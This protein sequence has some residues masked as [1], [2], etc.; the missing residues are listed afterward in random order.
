[1]ADESW[2]FFWDS[3]EEDIGKVLD[4]KAKK[5]HAAAQKK[6]QDY[7]DDVTKDMPT[8]ADDE[9]DAKD[10]LKKKVEQ[11]EEG[12][13]LTRDPVHP[14]EN[15]KDKKDGD[16][17]DG[18]KGQGSTPGDTSGEA[19]TTTNPDDDTPPPVSEEEAKEIIKKAT[20]IP[21][22]VIT[23]VDGID[24]YDI[25]VPEDPQDFIDAVNG[26]APMDPDAKPEPTDPSYA[27]PTPAELGDPWIN[28]G[29]PQDEFA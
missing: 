11:T 22:H 19:G 3:L 4:A 7:A 15:D 13:E 20:G 24:F 28:P 16:K 10:W 29:N 9:K 6:Q 12:T 2:E 18:D 1:F 8:E 26:D 25:K 23:W 27:L 17:K 5:D 21:D 14:E